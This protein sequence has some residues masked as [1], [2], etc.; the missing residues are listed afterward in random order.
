MSAD[1]ARQPAG[2]PTGGQ[3]A[4]TARAEAATT[5]T[6]P[7]LPVHEFDSTGTGYDR[8]QVDDDIHDGDVLAVP[9]EGVYGFL[10]QAWPVAITVERGEFHA[11]TDLDVFLADNPQYATGAAQA[12]HLA[13]RAGRSCVPAAAAVPSATQMLTDLA[14]RCFPDELDTVY[15]TLR[16]LRHHS[17]EDTVTTAARAFDPKHHQEG[18]Q[19]LRRLAELPSENSLAMALAIRVQAERTRIFGSPYRQQ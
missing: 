7:A 8:T 15:R 11:I 3:F 17:L 2:V 4:T 5:L 16:R 19:V 13:E 1:R 14:G 18:E 12:R 9:S 10:Y 6:T